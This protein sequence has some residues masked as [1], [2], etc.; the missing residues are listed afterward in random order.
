[1]LMLQVAEKNKKSKR[2]ALLM[3]GAVPETP[4]ESTLQ[5]PS[6]PPASTKVEITDAPSPA[7]KVTA[8]PPSS[9]KSAKTPEVPTESE[10]PRPPTGSH[11][12]SLSFVPSHEPQV[13]PG[14]AFERMRMDP[15]IKEFRKRLILGSGIVLGCI[16]LVFLIR[17]LTS[18]EDTEV[19]RTATTEIETMPSLIQEEE[20]PPTPVPDGSLVF[21]AT[22]KQDFAQATTAS[23]P[24]VTSSQLTMDMALSLEALRKFLAAPNWKER[25]AWSRPVNG[26]E[27]RM[28][29]FYTKNADGPVAHENIVESKEASGNFFEHTVV[30]EGGGRRP[31]MV[32]KTA[33]GPR[34]DWAAFHGVGD[35][36][37][38]QLM[39][40]KPSLPVTMR[41]MVSDGFFYENQFG[42]PRLLKCLELRCVSE[43]GAPMIH[44]YMERD[45]SAAQQIEFWLKQ[46]SGA[47][48]PLTLRIKYPLNA[49]SP[50]QVW[51][52][53]IVRQGWQD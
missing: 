35:M 9:E 12:R 6:R 46:S 8:S 45:S 52:T 31:A 3:G 51:V 20:P 53:E 33:K 44:G 49:P 1:M 2:R 42:S 25:L 18:G 41:V 23:S 38:S 50:K 40:E 17:A 48:L 4:A 5:I 37:W 14:D 36:G 13:L 32:E 11:A 15:E 30:L 34:V 47:A 21:K 24:G 26:L 27:E 28:A 7:A 22:G 16:A 10:E 29:A 19:N 39:E 43:P